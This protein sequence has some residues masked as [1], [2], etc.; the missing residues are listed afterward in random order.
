[1]KNIIK[2]SVGKKRNYFP[3]NSIFVT[4]IITNYCVIYRP[5][6]SPNN[7]LSSTTNRPLCYF[8][9]WATGYE[10]RRPSQLVGI[11]HREY[12]KWFWERVARSL[13][14]GA[15]LSVSRFCVALKSGRWTHIPVAFL[16]KLHVTRLYKREYWL[17]TRD[18]VASRS[19]VRLQY[20]SSCSIFY[21][22][23]DPS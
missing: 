19:W 9:G 13:V 6:A 12:T 14:P 17:R 7:L 21:Q 20:I 2:F 10:Y 22:M 18:E 11:S 3:N 15:Q 16:L 8:R 1:V 4:L 5:F 23:R